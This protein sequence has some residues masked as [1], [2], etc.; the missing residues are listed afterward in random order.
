MQYLVLRPFTSYGVFYKKGDIVDESMIRSPYLR[1]SEGKIVPA[2]SSARVP[3]EVGPTA[4]TSDSFIED[5]IKDT[6]ETAEVEAEAENKQEE[7]D[8][9]SFSFTP[10]K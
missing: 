10:Q 5:S 4:E 8:L 1:K 9:F 7:K 3:E 6:D 2:V